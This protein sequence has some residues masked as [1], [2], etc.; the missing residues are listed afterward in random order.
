MTD[1]ESGE[2]V[3]EEVI[4]TT[5]SPSPKTPAVSK[6]PSVG[7]STVKSEVKPQK[8]VQKQATIEEQATTEKQVTG[9]VSESE[10]EVEVEEEG[11]EEEEEQLQKFTEAKSNKYGSIVSTTTK[12]ETTEPT[13]KPKEELAET[14]KEKVTKSLAQMNIAESTGK[15]Q[16]ANERAEI[17]VGRRPSAAKEPIQRPTQQYVSIPHTAPV[18]KT[19]PMQQS[20]FIQEAT[21]INQYS[22]P[23]TYIQPGPTLSQPTPATYQQ[24]ASTTHQIPQENIRNQLREIVSDIDRAVEEHKISIQAPQ[25]T[26]HSSITSKNTTTTETWKQTSSSGI[27]QKPSYF[28]QVCE[29]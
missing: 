21:P 10:E 16:Q 8:S 6:A 9:E 20:A 7:T 17:Q 29:R 3:I 26:V 27:L 25:P 19:A 15:P 12:I 22:A 1:D 2:D 28:Y 4:T 13:E 5:T 11:E 14:N 24:R 23:S 18:Q